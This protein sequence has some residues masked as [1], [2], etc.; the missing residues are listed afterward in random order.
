MHL[1]PLNEEHINL[2]Q[3]L[4]NEIRR[5]NATP[6]DVEEA[7]ARVLSE[8]NDP[9]R[10]K[11]P[12]AVPL[13]AVVP[14]RAPR[15]EAVLAA[16]GE[17]LVWD[18]DAV[19]AVGALGDPALPFAPGDPPSIGELVTPNV[20]SLRLPPP[21]EGTSPE[22]VLRRALAAVV[23]S[24]R[25]VSFNHGTVCN[26][27][28]MSVKQFTAPIPVVYKL[29]LRDTDAA[30][31][32][33]VGRGFGVKV[34][35]LDTGT[36]WELSDRRDGRT[37]GWLAGVV[38]DREPES[39]NPSRRR[40]PFEHWSVGHGTSVAGII[41]MV[42]PATHVHVYRVA[43]LGVASEVAVAQAILRAARDGADIINLSLGTPALPEHAPLAIEDALAQ[44]PPRVLVVAS[45]GNHGTFAKAYPAAFD[46]VVAVGATD[47]Q[48][49]RLPWSGKG[50][51]VTVSTRGLVVAPYVQ[52]RRVPGRNPFAAVAGTSFSC[53]QVSGALA[54]LLSNGIAP[55]QAVDALLANGHPEPDFG[56]IVRVLDQ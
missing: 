40:Q 11:D 44:L 22:E 23:S 20:R 4:S 3:G 32:F 28:T 55:S 6:G 5:V 8:R 12:L 25:R 43:V 19:A 10:R 16:D 35:V 46:R 33:G 30:T 2:L 18:R 13:R 15:S 38:E 1:P 51:H 45:A 21:A 49:R 54:V 9:S 17:L 41:R 24:G 34:A 56:V 53:P 26:I 29:P 52:D 14:E 50:D 47:L 48:D 37:D 31:G 39:R 27:A 36:D 42:A 7:I